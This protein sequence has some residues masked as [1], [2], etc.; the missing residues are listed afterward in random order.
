M[1]G[2]MSTSSAQLRGVD[3]VGRIESRGVDYIPENERHSKPLELWAVFVTGNLAFSVIVFGWLPVVFGLGW[4]STVSSVLV[5]T[6][7]GA[8]VAAP[9]ALFGPRTGTNGVVSSGAHFGIRGRAI[10]AFL[11]VAFALLYAAISIWTG[12]DALVAGAARLF[13][14]PDGDGALALGHAVMAVAIVAVAIYGHATLVALQKVLLPL[15]AALL[16]LGIVAFGGDFD[17]DYAGGDY[18]LG[19][20]WTTWALSVVVAAAGPIS[21]AALLSDYT[22]YMS[23]RHGDRAIVVAAGGSVFVGLA[24]ASLFGAFTAVTFDDL[25]SDYVPALVAA[26]AGWYVLPIVLVGVL[27]GI[28]QGVINVYSIGLNTDALLPRLSRA[29][30]TVLGSVAA[31]A[32]VYAGTL[33][34][35]A[36]ASITAATLVLNT[37]AIPWIAVM[38]LG[39]AAR[40]GRYVAS[41]L[42][43]F[44]EGRTGG[45]YWFTAGWNSRATIA[46]CAGSI[47]GLLCV[48]SDLYTGPWANAV[49]G[50]DVT[51]PASGLVAAVAYGSLLL[52]W[53][54]RG[55]GGRS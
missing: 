17:A 2:L 51:I 33:V 14:T 32:L 26:A 3:T 45:V 31:V 25:E 6:A 16:A 22:R 41:D 19:D 13:G 28:G 24:G 38:L 29:Q 1:E 7:L 21:Y 20:F 18:L 23:Q 30:A 50:I 44:N 9:L 53:P 52:L 46:W 36:V 12:G 34:F 5:G 48:Q 11:Q 4:W 15:L 42:Q 8:L 55:V 35:D 40:R 27:G 49:R 43:V 39:F 37:V 54:E 10:G 47:V